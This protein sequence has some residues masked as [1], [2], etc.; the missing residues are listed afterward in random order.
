MRI[1]SLALLLS[2]AGTPALAQQAAPSAA[3]LHL[4]V[5]TW[6]GKVAAPAS[7]PAQATAQPMA[8]NAG[9]PA[10]AARADPAWRPAYR[11]VP[12]GS[13]HMLGDL[14]P[15][16]AAQVDAQ[17][18]TARAEAEK[19]RAQAQVQILQAQAEAQAQQ[20]S[21]PP[22]ALPTSIYAPTPPAA[23]TQVAVQPLAAPQQRIAAASP[24]DQKAHYYSLH[25][26]YGQAPDPVTLSPQFL[27][28]PSA[29]LAEPPPPPV[30]RLQP[31]ATAGQQTAA[32]V[33]QRDASAS[34]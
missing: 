10:A 24:Y 9:P 11:P 23:Q 22:A 21:R 13:S 34:N 29:D 2:L 33:A 7:R 6:P 26:Q 16:Q 19:A 25:R 17:R 12:H 30:P 27:S 1:L 15:A 18:T 3:T 8:F 32:R 4:R 14:T 20:S 31:N 28:A 5:L